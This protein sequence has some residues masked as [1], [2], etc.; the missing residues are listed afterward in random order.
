MRSVLP[1]GGAIDF[2][3]T[4]VHCLLPPWFEVAKSK[5]TP[6]FAKSCM[7]DMHCT[8]NLSDGHGRLSITPRVAPFS[9]LLTCWGSRDKNN[10]DPMSYPTIKQNLVD[11]KCLPPKLNEFCSPWPDKL[12]FQGVAPV[13]R[14]HPKAPQPFIMWYH[15]F[16]CLFPSINTASMLSCSYR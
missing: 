13:W 6:Y 2:P 1:I 9:F 4:I 5:T 3:S 7:H 11:Q 15:G 12:D 14:F 10:Y 8:G 16:F